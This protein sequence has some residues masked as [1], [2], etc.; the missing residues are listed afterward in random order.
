MVRSLDSCMWMKVLEGQGRCRPKSAVYKLASPE[1]TEREQ[2]ERP[3]CV[4]QYLL[5]EKKILV[6]MNYGVVI[7]T[8][9]M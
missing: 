2:V 8:G 3:S 9:C 5:R 1:V 4:L 6:I 7:K